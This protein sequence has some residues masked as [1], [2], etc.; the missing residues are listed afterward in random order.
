MYESK[1]CCIYTKGNKKNT[2]DCR[3]GNT[4]CTSSTGF[5][6]AAVANT[7]FETA[8]PSPGQIDLR[9]V[10]TN[11]QATIIEPPSSSV[12]IKEYKLT[13]NVLGEVVKF[14]TFNYKKI[15]SLKWSSM[16]QGWDISGNIAHLVGSQSNMVWTEPIAAMKLYS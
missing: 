7:C 3:C 9:V 14:P 11:L 8:L 10:G 5:Y 15:D 13:W 16:T 4:E 2:G 12:T 1:N 6:C